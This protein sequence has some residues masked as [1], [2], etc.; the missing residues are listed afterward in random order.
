MNA[1]QQRRAMG[2]SPAITPALNPFFG[3][4]PQ[5]LWNKAKDFFIYSVEWTEL[6]A[7]ETETQDIAIESDSDFLIVAANCVAYASDAPETAVPQKPFLVTI[8]DNGSGRRLMNRATHLDNFIGTGQLPGYWPFPKLVPRASTVS[9]TLANLDTQ[10][11]YVV[12]LSYLGF[13]IFSG[14]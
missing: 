9:T 4:L 14:Y 3:L 2:T 5:E 10:N 12:K 1:G 8:F 7:S 11:A 6:A 13:K